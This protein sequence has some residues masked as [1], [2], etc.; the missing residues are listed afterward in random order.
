[1]RVLTPYRM[2]HATRRRLLGV[3]ACLFLYG[4]VT[5]LLYRTMAAPG[6]GAT[7]AVQVMAGT[8][9]PVRN[10]ALRDGSFFVDG[11]RFVI[12]SVGWDPVRPGELPWTRG[13]RPEEIESDLT[14]IQAA[15]FNTVRTWAPLGSAELALAARHGLHVLQGIWVPPDGDFADADFR[16]RVLAE[17]A[18]TVESSRW[19]PAV[20]GY[21]VLNE[22]RAGAVAR[23]GLDATIAFLRE[24]VATVHALDPSAPVGYASWPGMEALDDPL[25]DFVA[26]NIYPHRPRIVMDELGIPGY[27][28]LLERTVAKGRPLVISEFGV[29]VSPGTAAQVPGRGGA[30]E[31][32]QASALCALD[33]LFLRC[34]AAGTSVFQW[35]DGWWKNHEIEGDE[36]SHDPN[37]PEEWFGLIQ[38]DG[39]EDRTGRPRPALAALERFHR[40]VLV[41]SREDAAAPGVTLGR[42]VG[43]APPAHALSLSPARLQVPPGGRFEVHVALRGEQVAGRGITIA[44]FAEDHPQEGCVH[45]RTDGAGKAQGRFAAP[46]AETVLSVVAFENDPAIPSAQRAV[47]WAVVEVRRLP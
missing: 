29:S 6:S 4:G 14:R 25:L 9:P 8:T 11:E 21:L 1:M 30:S 40:E 31:A 42:D 45:A 16:R 36:N 10:V 33:S 2:R 28:T 23:A 22:P 27:L 32:E 3:A 41:A 7:P 35:S 20:L 39:V 34:G 37:D 47:A 15:G 17:V 19:S 26:F 46:E 13:F 18:R 44:T 12:Q 43:D 38:F 5:A 24:V